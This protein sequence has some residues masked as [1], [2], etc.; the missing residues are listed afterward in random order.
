MHERL[1]IL[2]SIFVEQLLDWPLVAKHLH[3]KVGLL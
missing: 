1:Q 2:Y 3:G